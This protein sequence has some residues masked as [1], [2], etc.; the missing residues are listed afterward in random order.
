MGTLDAVN[1]RYG[2]GSIQ[3]ASAGV[4]R[5]DR[6]WVMKQ[7][8]NTPNY[9]TCCTDLPRAPAAARRARPARLDEKA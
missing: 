5:P 1:T 7:E 9:T 4:A 3:L 8:L 2:R 6:A